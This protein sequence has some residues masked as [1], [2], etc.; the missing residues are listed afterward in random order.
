MCVATKLVNKILLRRLD[1]VLD[2]ALLPWQSGFRRGR[3]TIEQ[4]T[5]LRMIIDRCKTRKKDVVITFVDFSKAFDSVD[6]TAL[7]QIIRLY[8]VPEELAGP[9]MALYRDTTATVRTTDGPTELFPTTTGIL[10][11][12]TLAPYL[13]VVVMDYVLRTSLLCLQ[14]DAFLISQDIGA[15][16]ALAYA[17]DVALLAS[18]FEGAE[19]MVASLMT[20]SATVGLRLNYSK[21]EVLA[22]SSV[23]TPSPPLP[24]FPTIKECTNFT[25]LGTLMADSLGAFE[26]RRRLAWVASRTLTLIYNSTTSEECKVG[27]FRAIIEPVLLYGCESWVTPQ[28]LTAQIDASH[29]ALLRAAINVHW[30]QVIR[31]EDLYDRTGVPPASTTMR[32]KRLTLFGKAVRAE[33][34]GWPLSRVLKHQP[35]EGHRQRGRPPTTMWK[36]LAEDLAHL[37][38]TMDKAWDLASN[39]DAWERRLDSA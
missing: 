25:Y 18:S 28:S 30:P 36:V 34:L 7:G 24:S 20:T 10:Q 33:H 6:R 17:D 11:G 16:P 14:N 21:T 29:R 4:I 5:A 31:N 35:R 13:F 39:A 12:D 38:L 2:K 3:S 22:F 23:P 15:L 8:G 27:L 9:I 37:D 26:E 32:L 19:R 1:N